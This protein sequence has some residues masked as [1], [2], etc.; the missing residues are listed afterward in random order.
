M[1]FLV[2]ILFIE[3]IDYVKVL[4]EVVIP[5]GRSSFDVVISI[6][7]D[8]IVEESERFQVSFT[9]NRTVSRVTTTSRVSTVTILDD[10]CE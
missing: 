10:D 5:S 2:S 8:R 4:K 9:V 1:Q 7:D 6:I 3:D